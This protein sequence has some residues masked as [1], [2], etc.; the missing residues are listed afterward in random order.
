MVLRKLSKFWVD[1]ALGLSEGKELQLRVTIFE[2][3]TRGEVGQLM[4]VWPRVFLRIPVC[5]GSLKRVNSGFNMVQFG[6]LRN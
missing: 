3:G 2:V 6:Y 4:L 5:R 1:Q